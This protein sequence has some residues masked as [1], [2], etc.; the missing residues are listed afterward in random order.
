MP[1]SFSPTWSACRARSMALRRFVSGSSAQ[2]SLTSRKWQIAAQD[3][4][5]P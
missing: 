5:G 2:P 4:A 3:S 1:G